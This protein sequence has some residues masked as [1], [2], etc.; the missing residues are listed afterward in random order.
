MLRCALTKLVVRLHTG[1]IDR[2]NFGPLCCLQE[3]KIYSHSG[4]SGF[5]VQLD[6]SFATALPLLRVFVVSPGVYGRRFAALET[7]AKVVMSHLVEL[8]IRRVNIVHLDLH[9]MSALKSLNL[10]DC[11]VSTVSAA[12]STMRLEFCGMNQGTV[13]VSPNLRSLTTLGGGLYKLDGSRC[14]HGL[15]IICMNKSSIEWIGA[16]PNISNLRE[17]I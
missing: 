9:F 15:S 13:L 14:R 3:L 16:K 12:C 4:T 2:D 11:T 8:D 17:I 6:D 5:E 7:T 1:R 10:V